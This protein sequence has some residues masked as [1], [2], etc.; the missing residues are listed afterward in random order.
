VNRQDVEYNRHLYC[1][2]R[3]TCIRRRN[4]QCYF[5]PAT[6]EE[7]D[8]LARVKEIHVAILD[9]HQS[10]INGYLYRL[11]DAADIEIVAQ[12]TYAEDL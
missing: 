12:A 3:D 2:T 4:L 6:W 10:I 1:F 9:D 5:Q 7:V 8:D 11:G